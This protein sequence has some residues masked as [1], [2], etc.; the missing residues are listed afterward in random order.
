MKNLIILIVFFV[1][2]IIGLPTA[3]IFLGTYT[4]GF[5]TQKLY[6][7]DHLIGEVN[8]FLMDLG[9][10][11]DNDV[12]I[13]GYDGFLF[14]GNNYDRVTDLHRG[15][16]SKDEEISKTIP[17]L[18]AKQ[19][20][21][22]SLNIPSVFVIAPDKYSIYP[23]KLPPWL[24]VKSER[25][26]YSF[27]RES[28]RL[29]LNSLMLEKFIKNSEFLSFYKT[30]T[31]WNSYGSFVGYKA[32]MNYLNNLYMLDLKK[33]NDLSFSLIPRKGGDLANFMKFGKKIKDF[34]AIS[35]LPLNKIQK[36]IYDP[37][38]YKLSH[39]KFGLNS[40]SFTNMYSIYTRNKNALNNKKLL[41]IKDSFGTAN[42]IFYQKSFR[43]TIQVHYNNVVG[44][45]LLDLVLREKPDIIIFQAVERG[46]Y[47]A[48]YSKPWNTD[49]IRFPYI[50][51][52]MMNVNT[53]LSATW[54]SF[55]TVEKADDTEINVSASNGDPFF[56]LDVSKSSVIAGFN[57][58]NVSLNSSTIGD[59][60]VFFKSK[61]TDDY[62][63]K[64]SIR[65]KLFP[66]SNDFSLKISDNVYKGEFRFDFPLS[67]GEFVFKDFSFSK[68]NY[69]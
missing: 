52:K 18:V 69:H 8:L 54:N 21:F 31:H 58:I 4:D 35:N 6:S 50:G 33:I 45:N 67:G 47:T 16:I 22:D 29:G 15:F 64:N 44:N 20:F 53:L 27:F 26:V 49:V 38:S 34:E 2:S 24:S 65:V 14:L 62:S 25:P 66:G 60:Q 39:C 42:S 63:E 56:I 23:N 7:L 46:F 57:T 3:N 1:L 9:I 28:Q 61:I 41:Y 13:V 51:N 12:C 68:Y 40:E 55:T 37:F 19:K 59:V 32:T 10:S 11:L 36:C 48:G 30:D 17:E 5:S 43:E